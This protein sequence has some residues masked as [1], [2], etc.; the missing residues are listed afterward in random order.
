M[1]PARNRHV[2][3]ALSINYGVTFERPFVWV[4]PMPVDFCQDRWTLALSVGNVI[5]TGL[6]PI[7]LKPAVRPIQP[8]TAGAKEWRK[9]SLPNSYGEE[10]ALQFERFSL[11]NCL[12]GES[13][14]PVWR[15]RAVRSC[16]CLT[17]G[18]Y[19]SSWLR[20]PTGIPRAHLSI[21]P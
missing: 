14:S 17:P 13:Q 5:L 6:S 4:S 16:M 12:Q 8:S 11:L 1:E 15:V 9:E 2:S 18:V 19:C 7:S 20:Y 21:G 10:S 3:C